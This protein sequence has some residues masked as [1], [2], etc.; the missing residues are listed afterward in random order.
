MFVAT[1]LLCAAAH[2]SQDDGPDALRAALAAL[3]APPP[4][5]LRVPAGEALRELPAG[6]L[7]WLRD[8]L[9]TDAKTPASTNA[10]HKAIEHLEA[11]HEGRPTRLES[12]LGWARRAL[13][14][15]YRSGSATDPRWDAEALAGLDA[16]AHLLADHPAFDAEAG[17]ALERAIAAG[18]GDPLVSWAAAT[19]AAHYGFEETPDGH[20]TRLD[21][22]ARRMLARGAHPALVGRALAQLD[23][24]RARVGMA[25]AFTDAELLAQL[26][27][28]LADRETPD[29]VVVALA[30][31]TQEAL[32]GGADDPEPALAAVTAVFEA[33]GA[34]ARLGPSV[35]G[36]A[37]MAWAR[38]LCGERA[39]YELPADIRARFDERKL[40]AATALNATLMEEDRT[41]LGFPAMIEFFWT[42]HELDRDAAGT[43]FV[44]GL[45]QDP[46]ALAVCRAWLRFLQPRYGQSYDEAL[47]LGRALLRAGN[48]EGRVATLLLDVHDHIARARGLS[49]P[50]LYVRKAA[51]WADIQAA[52]EEALRR[53]PMDRRL[54]QRYA[55]YAALAGKDE[56]ARRAF[57]AGGARPYREVFGSR[58]EYERLKRSVAE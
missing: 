15:A 1:L 49:K 21:A 52:C 29:A 50:E 19:W 57:E 3:D 22:D 31:V 54:Q 36:Q 43:Y 20:L 14:E 42:E 34:R 8:A 24:A 26:R 58:E 32:R 10:V 45:H 12:R 44:V 23:R 6:A 30:L 17:A 16:V 48:F 55:R 35:R 40:A 7:P 56:L 39:P 47:A 4:E 38:E 46:D 41:A 51:V 2:H 53:F 18:C 25:R 13:V 27:G 11:R 37:L 5:L 28:A 33:D 9:A